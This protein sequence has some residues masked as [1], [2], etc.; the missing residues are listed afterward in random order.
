M[1]LPAGASI[2][3]TWNAS[4]SGTT[5]TVRFNN[6]S[7]NGSIAAGQSTDWGFQGTGTGTGMTATCAAR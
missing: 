1:T 3:N 2:T 6:V 7:Y 4:P 5:G